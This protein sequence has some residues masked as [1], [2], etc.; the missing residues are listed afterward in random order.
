[1]YRKL[2]ALLL[3]VVVMTFAMASDAFA[4]LNCQVDNNS[5]V[6]ITIVLQGSCPG[7]PASLWIT[8]TYVIPAGGSIIIPILAPPCVFSSATVN[9]TDYLVGYSGPMAPPNP[10]SYIRLLTTW[11][12]IW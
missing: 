9:G 10:P 12:Q 7:P 3:A 11:I 6:T 8:P 2:S 5:P 1:M 4:Q